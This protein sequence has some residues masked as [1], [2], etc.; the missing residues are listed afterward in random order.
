ML[1][2]RF[3][4]KAL[5]RNHKEGTI[6]DPFPL[7]C[8]D[9]TV[10][11]SLVST[12]SDLSHMVTKLYNYD[13]P[14]RWPQL[15]CDETI[16]AP[17]AK[18]STDKDCSLSAQQTLSQETNRSSQTSPPTLQSHIISQSYNTDLPTSLN[19]FIPYT[20]GCEPWGPDAVMGTVYSQGNCTFVKILNGW[21][22]SFFTQ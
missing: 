5:S 19:Y 17:T 22:K 16:L 6:N 7:L 13:H 1:L 10:R 18:P 3:T 11:F 20:I 4:I 12:S 2:N 21:F 9:S 14:W 15:N 8:F